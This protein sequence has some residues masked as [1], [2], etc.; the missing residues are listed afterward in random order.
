MF[1]TCCAEPG[2]F[3]SPLVVVGFSS[4]IVGIGSVTMPGFVLDSSSEIW[5]DPREGGD[6]IVLLKVGVCEVMKIG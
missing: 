1:S 3:A 4:P 5:S 6:D 2:G